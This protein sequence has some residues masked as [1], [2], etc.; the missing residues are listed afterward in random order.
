M[1]IKEKIKQYK[2]GFLKWM[3]STDKKLDKLT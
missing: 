3:K 2:G 1:E